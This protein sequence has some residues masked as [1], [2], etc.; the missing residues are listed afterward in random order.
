[1][2]KYLSQ[3]TIPISLEETTRLLKVISISTDPLA[4]R[5]KALFSVYAFSGIRK[6]EALALRVS[7][8]DRRSKTILLPKSKGSGK[9]KQLIPS[10][11]CNI[12]DG[13]IE[14]NFSK[15]SLGENAVVPLPLFHGETAH[16]F[17]SGRQASN[18]FEKWKKVA[19]IRDTLTVHSFRSGYAS[20]LYQSSKD[21]L[22]VSHALGHSSFT[23]T[24]RYVKHELLNLS[25]LL[26]TAFSGNFT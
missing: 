6:S 23:T 16:V 11:L 18:R 22:L 26:E 7:N 25:E 13:Y 20:R 19:R 9:K 10:V 4:D 5:D 2:S 3:E 8:Y 17:L 15:V 14:T 24:E 21:P 12:L 1:M